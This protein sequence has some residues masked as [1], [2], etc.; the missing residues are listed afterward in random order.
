MNLLLFHDRFGSGD[1]FKIEI[2][3]QLYDER[4][5]PSGDTEK[6]IIETAPLSLMP[7]SVHQFLRMVSEKLWDGLAFVHRDIH[8]H[9]MQATPLNVKTGARAIDRFENAGLTKLAFSEYSP[10][11]PH[12]AYTVGFSGRPG[13]P[14]FYINTVDNSLSH[15]PLE[16]HGEPN[17]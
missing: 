5:N 16:Q 15:G 17:T 6:F 9:V 3:L 8:S 7:H 10:D 1:S 14:D 2:S 11:Y 12:L 13:G 4:G